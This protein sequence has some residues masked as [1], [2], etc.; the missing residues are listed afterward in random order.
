M[1]RSA[2]SQC[3]YYDMAYFPELFHCLR[4][5]ALSYSLRESLWLQGSCVSLEGRPLILL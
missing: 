3:V 4:R 2:D 5:F 1:T